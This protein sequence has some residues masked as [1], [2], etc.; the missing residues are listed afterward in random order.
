MEIIKAIISII[1][2]MMV[3][4]LVITL[5]GPFLKILFVIIVLGMIRIWWIGRKMRQ[6]PQYTQEPRQ[7]RQQ[8]Q[9]RTQSSQSYQR[10]SGQ[11]RGDVFDAEYTEEEIKD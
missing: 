6:R 11:V 10:S 5:A 2:G 3:L 8:S 1:I 7:H 4:S 9:Q